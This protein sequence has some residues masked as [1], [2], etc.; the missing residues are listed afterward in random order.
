MKR[1]SIRKRPNHS[2]I[3]AAVLIAF[4][5]LASA[6]AGVVL[7][8]PSQAVHAAQHH[9]AH[10]IYFPTIS[11]WARLKR[12]HQAHGVFPAVQGTGNLAYGG[13]PVQHS[14][15]TYIIFW[16]A[17]FWGAGRSGSAPATIVQ[18]Y[19]NDFGGT[20]FENLLTHYFR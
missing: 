15:K 3:V 13:G 2:G 19:F 10:K 1:V 14:P 16:G 11:E 18:N 8:S 20:S 12:T 17:I 9:N 7:T 5:A 6:L 4:L